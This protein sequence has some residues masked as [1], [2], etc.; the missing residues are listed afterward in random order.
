VHRRIGAPASDGGEEAAMARIRPLEPSEVGP[1]LAAIF[2]QMRGQGGN[3]SNLLRTIAYRP[4]V[5][6]TAAAHLRTV[7]ETGTVDERLKEMLAVRVSQ[8]NNCAH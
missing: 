1:A 7:L 5:A 2:E 6:E 3:V 8:I 4:A